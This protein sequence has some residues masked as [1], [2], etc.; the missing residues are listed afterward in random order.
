MA[1]QENASTNVIKKKM[2]VLPHKYNSAL[3]LQM[4]LMKDKYKHK[5]KERKISIHVS[6]FQTLKNPRTTYKLQVHRS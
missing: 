4:K 5:Y 3:F 6:F 1:Y 2:H